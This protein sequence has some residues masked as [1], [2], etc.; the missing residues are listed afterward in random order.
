[1]HRPGFAL[2]LAVLL[3][4]AA[5]AAGNAMV[6]SLRRG[7]AKARVGDSVRMLSP[8]VDVPKNALIEVSEGVMGVKL[9]DG[10]SLYFTS[11][12]SFRFVFEEDSPPVVILLS[13]SLTTNLKDAELTVRTSA[14]VV[15]SGEGAASVSY[16]PGASSATGALML[17][18]ATGEWRVAPISGKAVAVAAGSQ[19]IALSGKMMK[20]DALDE[21]QI[22]SVNEGSSGNASSFRNAIIPPPWLA[23]E[24]AK[25]PDPV[26]EVKRPE[27]RRRKIAPAS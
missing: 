10:T 25:S 2:I 18:V 19:Y 16:L 26:P 11:G 23:D 20:T 17:R 21:Q 12:T 13:G 22:I 14:G 6:F 8:G 7:V 5:S 1:M 3:P 15:S 24:L 9:P 4:V 27:P